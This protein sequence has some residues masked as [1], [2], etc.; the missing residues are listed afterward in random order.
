M[1]SDAKAS[2]RTRVFFI[3]VKNKFQNTTV[4]ISQTNWCSQLKARCPS[5]FFYGLEFAITGFKFHIF[6]F[7]TW[8]QIS[9]CVA[10]D[11]FPSFLYFFVQCN[12]RRWK[13]ANY[14]YHHHHLVLVLILSL[15]VS[16]HRQ[17][18]NRMLQYKTGLPLMFKTFCAH[19]QFI[20]CVPYDTPISAVYYI[21]LNVAGVVQHKRSLWCT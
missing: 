8:S 2:L 19:F 7:R 18:H 11:S 13:A 15:L 10:V 17:T 5:L 9:N 16:L 21:T 4:Y 12:P 6:I 14:Y 1:H 20:K 3:Q